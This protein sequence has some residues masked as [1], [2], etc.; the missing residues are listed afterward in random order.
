M[1][2]ATTN[3][4]EFKTTGRK[5]DL[6]SLAYMMVYLLKNQDVQFIWRGKGKNRSEIFHYIRDVKASMTVDDLLGI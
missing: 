4:F 1:I 5:D 2:F 6:M 3:Q